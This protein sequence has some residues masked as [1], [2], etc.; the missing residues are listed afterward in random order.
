MTTILSASL[1]VA[2]LCAMVIVVR[3]AYAR[4]VQ[5]QDLSVAAQNPEDVS[6]SS[7]ETDKEDHGVEKPQS[8]PVVKIIP[9]QPF[10]QS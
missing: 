5:A 4:L 2:S 6:N 9:T 10:L 1:I 8:F 3:G 7:D